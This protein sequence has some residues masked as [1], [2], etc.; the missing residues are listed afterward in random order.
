MRVGFADVEVDDVIAIVGGGGGDGGCVREGLGGR[1]EDGRIDV[2]AGG[3]SHALLVA[4][5]GGSRLVPD[6]SPRSLCLFL[7]EFLEF[8][9]EFES[10]VV[11]LGGC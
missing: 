11:A 2:H 6:V 9:G 1:G 7:L 10:F 5:G 3:G 4:A 8:V